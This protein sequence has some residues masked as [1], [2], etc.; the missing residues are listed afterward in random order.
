[1]ERVTV[2]IA[3]RFNGP[4]GSGHGG[5]SAGCAG[6]LVDAPAAE[7]TLRLPPPLETPL[8]VRRSDGA[9]ALVDGENVVAEARA[10][11]LSVAGPPPASPEEAADGA[12]RFSWKHDHPFPTCFGC[13]PERDPADALCLFCGPV[14]DGRFAVPW[15]P[16]PW[17]GDGVVEPLFAWAALDCPSSAPVH[18]TIGA[19]VVLGRFTVAL[20]APIEVGAPHVI[21]AWMER[22]DGRKRHTAVAIFAADGSRRA[23]GRAV[24][25]ELARPLGA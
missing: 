6:V 25:V 21:Q 5:Y 13:G 14:G 23:V 24:W 3:R 22:S 20:E 2:V 1:M 4:P 18:G 9:V 12:A 19:P 15:T 8:A 7:V 16:P 10:A 17:T 11:S